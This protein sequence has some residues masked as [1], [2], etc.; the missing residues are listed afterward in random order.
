MSCPYLHEMPELTY[1]QRGKVAWIQLCRPDSGNKLTPTMAEELTA[2]CQASDDDD[3][4]ELVVLTGSG[5]AFCLALNTRWGKKER[6][7]RKRFTRS[8]AICVASWRLLP[9]PNPHLPYSM[10]MRSELA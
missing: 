9:L 3:T 6:R 1:E 4:V 2:S 7:R 8:S 10:V 5:S